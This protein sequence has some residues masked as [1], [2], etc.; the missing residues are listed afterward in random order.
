MKPYTIGFYGKSNSGKTTLIIKIINYL[1]KEGLNVA[2]VKVSDKKIGIDKEGKDTFKHT[3]AGSNLVVF[4][5]KTET[6]FLFNKY[7]TNYKFIN[8]ISKL[9]KFDII[10]IEGANS[11]KIKK[12][13]I[14][15]IKKRK[16]TLFTYD[17]DFEKLINYIKNEI[18]WRN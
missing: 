13:R 4:S 15:N 5:T 1:S 7:M 16:N 6:D 10:I 11:E 12:I 2:S 14:G 18:Q 9:K 17:N 8:F 3:Q